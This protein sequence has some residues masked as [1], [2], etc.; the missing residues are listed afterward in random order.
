MSIG[1]LQQL[2]SWHHAGEAL[3][4]EVPRVP[5]DLES[6]KPLAALPRAWIPRDHDGVEEEGVSNVPS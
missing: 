2:P 6:D 3:H 1:L 5:Y 4:P